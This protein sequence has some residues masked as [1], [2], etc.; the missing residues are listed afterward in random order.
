MEEDWKNTCP[1]RT[2]RHEPNNNTKLSFNGAWIGCDGEGCERW[3]HGDCAGLTSE[4]VDNFQGE[5][6]CTICVPRVVTFPRPVGR[7]KRGFEWDKKNGEWVR[8]PNYSTPAEKKQKK[9]ASRSEEPA[10][11]GTSDSSSTRTE[12]SSASGSLKKR[13]TVT[14][15]SGSDKP[16]TSETFVPNVDKEEIIDGSGRSS[17]AKPNILHAVMPI[18]KS[19]S[20]AFSANQWHAKMMK[21]FN[22]SQ[23]SIRRIDF[24]PVKCCVSAVGNAVSLKISTV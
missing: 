5:F 23:A 3:M 13:K 7:A 18:S 12:S 10:T 15:A 14:S 1:C 24:A 19:D 16:V 4:Q 9:L 6:F 17:R 11:T 21:E 8:D 2:N 22:A 20:T